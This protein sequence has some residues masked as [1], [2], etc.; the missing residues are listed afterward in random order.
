MTTTREIPGRGFTSKRR[1]V[2]WDISLSP[3]SSPVEREDVKLHSLS[4]I[5][6][7]ERL[8][9]SWMGVDMIRAKKEIFRNGRTDTLR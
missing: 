9:K 3:Q 7:A 2:H 5:Y 4:M 1:E 6:P 8:L